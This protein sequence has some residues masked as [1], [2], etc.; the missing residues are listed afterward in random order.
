MNKKIK[1]SKLVCLAFGVC[2][3]T[4]FI[5]C[6][7]SDNS[8]S[9]GVP[10]Q[11]EQSQEGVFTASLSPENGTDGPD[12][13]N[14]TGT[15]VLTI[16]GDNF[17]STVSIIGALRAVH[18]QHIH[19]GNRCPTLA[20]DTNGDGVVDATEASAVYGPVVVPLDSDLSSNA[21]TFPEGPVYFYDQ[22]ASFSQMLGNLNIPSLAVEGLVIN[23]HGAPT[24]VELPA[25]SD[26]NHTDFPISC[27]V[28]VRQAVGTPAY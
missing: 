7:D 28:L 2:L 5:S 11:Q 17:T 16:E 22:T 6:G 21:G 10:P 25:S 3:L 9:G 20:D 23:I 4:T 24:S 1:T 12:I 26:G 14:A 18:A 19:S 27:G 8:Y 15:A 13:S